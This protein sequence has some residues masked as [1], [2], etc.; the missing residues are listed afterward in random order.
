MS[1]LTLAYSAIAR[2][3]SP[4][5]L[6]TVLGAIPLDT[7]LSDLTGLTLTSDTVTESGNV[8]TRTIV[9]TTSGAP[10]IFTDAQ[11]KDMALSWY[12]VTFAKALATPIVA[13][14]VVLS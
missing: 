8:A 3:L 12:T 4:S 13:A 1:T 11:M 9:Y 14:P 6:A 5:R 10:P 2:N 7:A